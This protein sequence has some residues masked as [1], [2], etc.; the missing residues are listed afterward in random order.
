MIALN[1][2]DFNYIMESDKPLPENEQTTFI[3]RAL[4]AT[5]FGEMQSLTKLKGDVVDVASLNDQ[6]MVVLRYG[7]VGW[8]NLLDGLGG[9]LEFDDNKKMD[10]IPAEARYELFSQIMERSTISRNSSKN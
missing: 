6:L 3:L 4:S 2:Q 5:E 8:K 7:L 9:T 10:L 1:L